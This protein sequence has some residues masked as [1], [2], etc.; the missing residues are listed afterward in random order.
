MPHRTAPQDPPF[1]KDDRIELVSMTEDPDP[2]AP[3]AT[4]TVVMDPVWFQDAWQV[5]VRWDD[6]RALN[7]VVPPDVAV[8]L[9]PAP[10][11]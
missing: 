4:G 2:V 8:R 6:G 3:G 11:P 10:R 1:A 9:E 7:L 5:V